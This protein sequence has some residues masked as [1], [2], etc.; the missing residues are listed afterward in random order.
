MARTRIGRRVNPPDDNLFLHL[1]HL[2][3][4]R[5]RSHKG[6][7][8][9]YKYILCTVMLCETHASCSCDC[10]W[11]WRSLANLRK[12]AIDQGSSTQR[13]ESLS[14]CLSEMLR[15]VFSFLWLTFLTGTSILLTFSSPQGL[16][17]QAITW[18]SE[19]SSYGKAKRGGG[20]VCSA[21]IMIQRGLLH[22]LM[23]P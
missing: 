4:R 5:K 2:S 20:L 7:R 13:L 15:R 22:Q 17:C 10:M 3:C 18:Q 1:D 11:L 12:P 6:A 8:R 14:V 21:T 9:Q 23:L 16:C 19:Q